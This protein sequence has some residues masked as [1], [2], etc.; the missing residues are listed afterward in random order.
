MGERTIGYESLPEKAD[1]AFIK[2]I[3]RVEQKYAKRCFV[4]LCVLVCVVGL[5]VGLGVCVIRRRK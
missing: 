3:R 1:T 2:H 5:G 4:G